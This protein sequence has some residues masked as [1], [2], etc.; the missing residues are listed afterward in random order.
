VESRSLQ[1]LGFSE[2]FASAAE[3]L[4]EGLEPARVAVEY[5]DQY[6]LV[7]A[8]GEVAAELSGRLKREARR[9]MGRP[10]VGDWVAIARPEG[11]GLATIRELFARKTRIARQAAGRRTQAQ[12]IAANI[13]VVFIVTAFNKDFNPRRIE[14]YLSAVADSGA[15]PVIAI[16]KLDL[17]RDRG[18]DPASY[19]DQLAT[20]APGVDAVAV[21]ATEKTSLAE[22][23]GAYLETGTTAALVG[24]S[25]VGKSTI[26]NWLTGRDRQKVGAARDSDDRG[27]HTTT[28]RELVELPTGAW[29]IDTPG[30]REFALWG[31][32]DLGDAFRDI[33]ELARQ[34]RFRDC[35]HQGEPGCAVAAA[36]ASGELS[37][38]RLDSYRKLRAEQKAHQAKQDV[39]ARAAK[40]KEGKRLAKVI[41][42]ASRKRRR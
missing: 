4:P 18:D 30:M 40:R 21:S 37:P 1:S 24:S 14:R 25:G 38:E 13:D 29:L 11:G 6:Q 33:E 32:D 17:C 12:V 36:I 42:E 20:T 35:S 3:A 9:P 2:F 5:Q 31:G 16:N 10:A 39:M 28:H 19:F 8:S 34:C 7:T 26:V 23:L 27:R 41:A 22:G 15:R